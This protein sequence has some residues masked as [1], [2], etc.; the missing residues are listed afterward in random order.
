MREVHAGVC[1]LH[2]GGH[3]LTCKIMR[4][5]YFWLTMEIDYFQF[6]QRCLECQMHGNLIHIPHSELH[7]L[8]LPWP[9]SV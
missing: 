3:M 7:A 5:E 9:F 6:V 2:M 1:G 8:T 4:L